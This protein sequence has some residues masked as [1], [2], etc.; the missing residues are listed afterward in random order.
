[1]TEEDDVHY[2]TEMARVCVECVRPLLVEPA[3]GG[4]GVMLWAVLLGV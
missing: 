4:R 1:M 3:A 2:R